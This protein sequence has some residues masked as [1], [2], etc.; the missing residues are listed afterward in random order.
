MEA[1]LEVDLDCVSS[2]D[3]VAFCLLV[4]SCDSFLLLPLTVLFSLLVDFVGTVL[5][6]ALVEIF[7]GVEIS[8]DRL[9]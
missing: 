1:P 9:M 4:L 3:S 7:I 2:L 6:F 8:A 5:S